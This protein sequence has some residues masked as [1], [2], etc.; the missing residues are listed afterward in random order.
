MLTETQIA[1]YHRDGYVTPDFRL[2]DEVIE[3]IRAGKLDPDV[4]VLF[5]HTGGAPALFGYAEEVLASMPV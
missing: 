3:D 2:P 5:L 1:Q 4:P